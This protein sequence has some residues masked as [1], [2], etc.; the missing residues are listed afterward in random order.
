[1]V[2]R[3]GKAGL[4]CS[5]LTQ[6]NGIA[7]R[8]GGDDPRHVAGV[9]HGRRK[10]GN[11]TGFSY[12]STDLAAKRLELLSEAFSRNKRIGALYNPREPAT[13]REMEATVTAGRSIGVTVTPIAA[14]DA[15]QLGAA[16]QMAVTEKTDGLIVFTHGFAVLSRARIMELAALH[17]LPVL[18]G[19]R[20]FVDEG[21]LMSYGPD[22]EI[23]V[24]RAAAYVDRIIKGTNPSELPIEQ[25]T[26]LQLVVN[27]KTAKRLRI[28]IPPK[29]LLRAE[30]VIE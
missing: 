23:L 4:C 13:K 3:G 5:T 21:G 14:Q 6:A 24:Q 25:P 27:L 7:R 2:V 19:W 12:M 30:T 16:F 11:L 20:D 17:R 28:T 9:E 1:M 18:Y 15:G 8:H 10:R 26:R 29:M 22:I